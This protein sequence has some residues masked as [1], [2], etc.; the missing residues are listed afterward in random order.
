MEKTAPQTQ[1]KTISETLII[2]TPRRIHRA[3]HGSCNS[4]HYPAV[5]GVERSG[6]QEGQEGEER[7]H[8]RPPD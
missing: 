6:M 2:V 4:T 7:L 3:C 8:A 5:I 1:S